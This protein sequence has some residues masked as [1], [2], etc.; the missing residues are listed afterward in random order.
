MLLLEA[1]YSDEV[2]SKVCGGS[3]RVFLLEP[4]LLVL[5][6]AEELL[7]LVGGR[8]SRL[9]LSQRLLSLRGESEERS[10]WSGGDILNGLELTSNLQSLVLCYECFLSLLDLLRVKVASLHE[11]V[12]LGR[13]GVDLFL[14][15]GDV[16]LQ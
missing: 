11:A 9:L 7:Q 1:L 3:H 14:V 15:H 10:R 2:L 8:Q 5:H 16:V 12:H 6:V 13:E 4:R